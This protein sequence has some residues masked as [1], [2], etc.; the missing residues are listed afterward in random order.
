[1]EL[2]KDYDCKILYHPGKANVMADTLSRKEVG[3]VSNFIIPPT[4]L[5]DLKRFGI[6]F[7]LQ[8]E[9]DRLLY[10]IEV[11]PNLLERKKVSQAQDDI[12]S[13]S[14]SNLGKKDFRKVNDDIVRFRHRVYVPSEADI[15]REIFSDSHSSSFSVH[16][17]STKMYK[18]LKQ[19]FWWPK[20]KMEIA[21]WVG[22][23][24]IC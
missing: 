11:R 22:R 6:E 3:K 5:E 2:L 10:Q 12:W 7:G 16:P 1:M 18:N 14:N 21:E 4:N 19:N 9:K 15:K 8:G 23:C 24:L 13:N 20:M 17:G